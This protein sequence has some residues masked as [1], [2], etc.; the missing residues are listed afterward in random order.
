MI[1]AE[2]ILARIHSS[3]E[4]PSSSHIA[5]EMLGLYRVGNSSID[6][7]ISLLEMDP[8]LSAR[9]I[10]YVNNSLPDHLWRV[11]SIR[12][13]TIFLGLRT[14]YRVILGMSLIGKN[15]K[16][17]CKNF[18][19]E[20]F[21]ALS[22]S[23]AVAA[24]HFSASNNQVCS[25]EL[26]VHGLL[27]EVGQLAF[28]T[29]Y[30]EKYSEIIGSAND[31][32]QLLEKEKEHFDIDNQE[33][34]NLLLREWGFAGYQTNIPDSAANDQI[35]SAT[36]Y[37][38]LLA[39]AKITAQNCMDRIDAEIAAVQLSGF[40]GRMGVDLDNY[41]DVFVSIKGQCAEW[42]KLFQVPE[43]GAMT[44]KHFNRNNREIYLHDS[45]PLQKIETGLRVLVADDDLLTLKRVEKLVS[46]YHDQVFVAENGEQAFELAICYKP[47]LLISDW[48]MPKM[49]GPELCKAIRS[50]DAIKNCYILMLTSCETDDEIVEAFDA[51]ADD[52]LVKPFSAKVL[53]ARVKSGRRLML[54]QLEIE[55][56]RETIRGIAEELTVTNKKLQHM[57]LNDPLT[58]L[59]NRRFAMNLMK[60]VWRER[61]KPGGHI[62]CIMVDIDNFKNIN[63]RYGH[64]FGDIVLQN[65]AIRLRDN[66]RTNDVVCR[67]GGEEFLV[68]CSHGDFAASK[69]FANRLCNAVSIEPVIYEDIST[70]VTISLGL[71]METVEMKSY[72]MLIKE[73]DN[74]MYA[75]KRAG[76]NRL[77]VIGE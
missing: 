45:E 38:D 36:P 50:I 62:S 64:E 17:E 67:L 44:Y 73:A 47:H 9:L 16:A 28:A 59:P 34:T 25:D 10:Q 52:Y 63:D 66:L 35:Q 32:E 42:M 39:M 61:N 19:Y 14:V 54:Q 37:P 23:T 33:L 15:I 29:I 7:Y 20:Y 70:D 40:A 8:G 2:E 5:I 74:A 6:D 26:F 24:R 3:V 27:S 72:S 13:A 4:L 43:G 58:E 11:E 57:A 22:L 69:Q 49:N 75:A 60:Q 31:R 77:S 30:P 48:R 51:G 76:K 21:W 12:E 1:P 55:N 68:I 71:A 53:Q 18:D 41:D 46:S 65:V 56:D